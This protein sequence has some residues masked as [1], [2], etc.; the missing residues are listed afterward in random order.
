MNNRFL[1]AIFTDPIN[2]FKIFSLNLKM[3]LFRLQGKKTIVYN[4]QMDYFYNTFEPIYLELLKNDKIVVYFAYYEGL[5]KLHEYLKI[6]LSSKYLISSTIS[7]FVWFDMFITAEINGPDF[8][9]S[10]L[11]THKIQ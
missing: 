8:P 6:F 3:L 4:I 5:Q 10:F 11:P 1:R 9:V 7:P 2:I